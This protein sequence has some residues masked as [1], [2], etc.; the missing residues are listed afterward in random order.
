MLLYI[1]SLTWKY[2]RFVSSIFYGFLSNHIP[3]AQTQQS[4]NQI[5]ARVQ[6][7]HVNMMMDRYNKEIE[8]YKTANI[9]QYIQQNV[10]DR[11]QT[12][13]VEQ[14]RRL[15]Q[16]LLEVEQ[17]PTEEIQQEAEEDDI[18]EDATE[19]ID[20]NVVSSFYTC[21]LL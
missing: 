7:H 10:Y 6:N 16:M 12:E 17:P 19:E 18:E 4:A 13:T 5:V 21:T 20:T 2:R 11:D 8:Y 9:I 3:T 14:Q 1:S 15:T